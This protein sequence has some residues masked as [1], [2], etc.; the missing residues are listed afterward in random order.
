MSVRRA[1]QPPARVQPAAALPASVLRQVGLHVEEAHLKD[2]RRLRRHR[3]GAARAVAERGRDDEPARAAAA[4]AEQAR[5]PAGQHLPAPEREVELPPLVV[6]KDAP[7]PGPV[8]RHPLELD[9]EPVSARRSTPPAD[10]GVC[11]PQAA[12]ELHQAAALAAALAAA[13]VCAALSAAAA[14]AA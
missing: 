1:S 5:V 7:V 10:H 11:V 13:R 14:A 6:V 3:A 12:R 9:T 8:R 4:H 2:E